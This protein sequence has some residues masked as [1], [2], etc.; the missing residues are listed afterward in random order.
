MACFLV[1]G[2]SCPLHGKPET[3]SPSLKEM[4]HDSC[5][6]RH[7]IDGHLSKAILY[8]KS[9]I[10][11][12]KRRNILKKRSPFVPGTVLAYYW[13]NKPC[14]VP[15]K[16]ACAVFAC[17]K[18]VLAKMKNLP[19]VPVVIRMMYKILNFAPVA[20]FEL[21]NVQYKE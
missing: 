9:I 19:E 12:V 14:C 7:Y 5:G 8:V 16:V 20:Y 6:I 15:R 10:F 18:F 11:W 17:A 2:L 21:M 4:S 1:T 13:N 3:K